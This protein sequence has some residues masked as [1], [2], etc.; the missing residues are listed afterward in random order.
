MPGVVTALRPHACLEDECDKSFTKQYDLSRHQKLHLTE[1]EKDALM[2]H[3][4][5]PGCKTKCLQ[6]SN[7]TIHMNKMHYKI[8]NKECSFCTYKTADSSKLTRHKILK[9]KY[10]PKKRL[11]RQSNNKIR[12]KKTNV[13]DVDMASLES[14][15]S[16]TSLGMELDSVDTPPLDNHS[17]DID[18]AVFPVHPPSPAS[19]GIHLSTPSTLP[20]SLE[21]TSPC[22]ASPPSDTDSDMLP[23]RSPSPPSHHLPISYSPPPTKAHP[24]DRAYYLPSPP[25]SPSS[26]SSATLLG[27]PAELF[28]TGPKDCQLPRIM[29]Y[30]G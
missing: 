16:G 3:C 25:R 12:K 29:S 6:L 2:H 5:A 20:P 17:V 14:P 7:L 10:K 23:P 22:V 9:H 24:T 11:S 30:A 13:E 26:H 21:S 19:T 8:K 18:M 28:I 1:E 4:K 27:L 15:R